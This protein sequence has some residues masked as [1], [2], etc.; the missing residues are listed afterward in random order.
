MTFFM[1]RQ[2]ETSEYL[3]TVLLN[4]RNIVSKTQKHFRK[5][6]DGGHLFAT[7]LF[8]SRNIACTFPNIFLSLTR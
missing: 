4:F 1:L 7:N 3:Q 6:G 5:A 2:V 8:F